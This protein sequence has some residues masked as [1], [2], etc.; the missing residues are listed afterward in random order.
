[1]GLLRVE[2][3]QALQQPQEQFLFDVR[4]VGT[5]EAGAA[6][7][8]PGLAANQVVNVRIAYSVS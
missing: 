6:G 2:L 8:L 7:E 4:G 3:W 1:M 5:A